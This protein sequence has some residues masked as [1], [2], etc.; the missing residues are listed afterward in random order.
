VTTLREMIKKSVPTRNSQIDIHVGEWNLDWSGDG[1]CYEHFNCVWGA[2][3]V[4]N[5]LRAGGLFL[6]YA[7]KNGPLGAMFEAA[8]SSLHTQRD[9]P[10]PIYFAL[11]MFT[12][13]HLF[14]KFDTAVVVST[15]DQYLVEISA[16]G[17]GNIVA[18]NKSPSTAYSTTFQLNGINSSLAQVWVKDNTMSPFDP[19]KG[20]T[21]IHISNGKFDYELPPYSVTTFVL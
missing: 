5:I 7:D 14:R 13:M 11:G 21:S 9:T 16:S 6:Q 15:S 2:S 3:V 18:I 20:A 17:N 4:G 10:M 8:N 12:G 1:K 19:P